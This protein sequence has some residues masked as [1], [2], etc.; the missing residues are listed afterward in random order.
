M[1]GAL[2]EAGPGFSF[3]SGAACA[4]SSTFGR[5]ERARGARCY[6]DGAMQAGN[7]LPSLRPSPIRKLKPIVYRGMSLL[8]SPGGRRYCAAIAS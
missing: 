4:Q 2:S 6:L 3:S 8:D 1:G 7:R 5:G